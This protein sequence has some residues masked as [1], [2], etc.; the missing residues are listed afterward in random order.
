MASSLNQVTLMGN[1]TRDPQLRY[2]GSS[3][4][5]IAEFGLAL[6]EGWLDKTTNQWRE[7]AVFV[8][9]KCFD[10]NAENAS[11]YLQRG[12]R[13]L[14]EGKLDVEEWNDKETGAKRSKTVIKASRITF[15]EPRPQ[16]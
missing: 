3:Q 5:A 2:I 4:T 6:N 9:V 7:K 10:K 11:E 15:L 13:C 16:S 12:H 1:I 14:I 8:D